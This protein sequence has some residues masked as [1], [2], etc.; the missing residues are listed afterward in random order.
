MKRV[1]VN[2]AAILSIVALLMF[3][4]GCKKETESSQNFIGTYNGTLYVIDYYA[5]GVAATN[6]VY[7][8]S[9]VVA[10][11]LEIT[12]GTSSNKV[13]LSLINAQLTGTGT[14]SGNNLTVDQAT[15]GSF[16]YT[17]AASLNGSNI[18]AHINTN[19]PGNNHPYESQYLFKGT[20]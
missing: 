16:N 4:A 9:Q 3:V 17:G 13:N 8:T 14:T 7:D 12:A 6:E 1:L 5:P 20:K 11:T 19:L 18:S 2:R 15:V 10:E